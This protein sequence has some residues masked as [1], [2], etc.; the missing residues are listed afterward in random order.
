MFILEN[1]LYRISFVEKKSLQSVIIIT[2][3][4]QIVCISN[5]KNSLIVQ[6]HTEVYRYNQSE[7]Q[8]GIFLCKMHIGLL[9]D[10]KHVY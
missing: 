5:L 7:Y 3:S 10:P 4:S 6:S 9:H 1:V 8:C 2:M